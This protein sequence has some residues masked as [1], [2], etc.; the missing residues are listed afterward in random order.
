MKTLKILSERVFKAGYILHKEMVDNPGMNE[1]LEWTMAY[2]P[3]GDYIGNSRDANRLCVQRGIKPEKSDPEHCVCSIGFSS[4]DGKW[5]GWSHRAIYGFKIGSKCKPGDCHFKASNKREFMAS[6]AEFYEGKAARHGKTACVV[7]T[8]NT[9][10]ICDY[11]KTW[12]KG[13]W[14]AKT[15]ADTKQMAI[16]FAESVS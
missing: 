1:P 9:G 7:T 16:D 6:C 3:S 14:T 10:V 13:S 2:T 11:P 4:K 12:G 5:Y 15:V 8:E